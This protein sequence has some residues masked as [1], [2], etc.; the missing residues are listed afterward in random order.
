VLW[1]TSVRASAGL[2][3]AEAVGAPD[4]GI[5]FGSQSTAGIRFGSARGA[6]VPLDDSDGGTAWLAHYRPDGRPAF[7]RTIAG[8]A[9]GRVGE[10]ARVG[11]RVYVDVTVR[12]PDNSINGKPI[13]VVGKDAS[14]WAVDVSA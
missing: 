1:A 7:A 4:G 14:V 5:L 3:G 11:S 6:G 10:I 13:S 8:T 9:N 2:D 12:G